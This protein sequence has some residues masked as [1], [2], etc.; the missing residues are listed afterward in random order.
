LFVYLCVYTVGPIPHSNFKLKTKT[1]SAKGFKILT[2]HFSITYSALLS[3]SNVVKIGLIGRGF[4]LS[5]R[6]IPINCDPIKSP[7]DISM[8]NANT[9][10]QNVRSC[11]DIVAFKSK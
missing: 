6:N 4:L 5:L 3:F 10:Q 2:L 1:Y 7:M 11:F 8:L 9:T